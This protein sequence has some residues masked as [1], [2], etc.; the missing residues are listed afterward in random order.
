MNRTGPNIHFTL[1]EAVVRFIPLVLCLLPVAVVPL[2]VP[3]R[4]GAAHVIAPILAVPFQL[5]CCMM[6]VF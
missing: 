1:G 3:R 6:V 5:F 2:V 4:V